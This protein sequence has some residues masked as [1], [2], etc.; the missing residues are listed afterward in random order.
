MASRQSAMRTLYHKTDGA[1]SMYA[2]DA[3]H[4]LKFKD[5]WKVKPWP[6]QHKA[7]E[8]EDDGATE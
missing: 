3:R 6:G 8:P 5:E 4:A 1:V 2:I 7:E